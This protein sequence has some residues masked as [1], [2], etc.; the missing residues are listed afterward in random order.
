MKRVLIL[1]VLLLGI[2]ASDALAQQND[3]LKK[4]QI[5]T[6]LLG[7]WKLQDPAQAKMLKTMGELFMRGEIHFADRAS[8]SVPKEQHNWQWSYKE[9][10][11]AL[12]ITDLDY[13]EYQEYPMYFKDL[14]TLVIQLVSQDLIYVRAKD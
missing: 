13:E 12:I 6:L 1:L 10:S 3:T 4:V 5:D 11:K 8:Y 9:A 7:R 14:N 2:G